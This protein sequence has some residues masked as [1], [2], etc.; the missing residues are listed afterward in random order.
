MKQT[1]LLLLILSGVLLCPAGAVSF[2]DVADNAWYAPAVEDVEARGLMEG[3]EDSRF[4]PEG[5]L[6]RAMVVTALWRMAGQPTAAAPVP[7]QDVPQDTWY[8][9]AVAWAAE[10]GAVKGF[11]PWVFGPDRPVTREQL[12]V[13]FYRWAE[14]QG[15]DISSDMGLSWKDSED[16]S[17][18]AW[19]AVAWAAERHLLQPKQPKFVPDYITTVDLVLEPGDSATRAEVAVFLSRF[20]RTFSDEVLGLTP[21]SIAVTTLGGT[22]PYLVVTSPDPS[23][24]GVRTVTL[25]ADLAHQRELMHRCTLGTSPLEI[26]AGRESIDTYDSQGRLTYLADYTYSETAVFSYLIGYDIQGNPAFVEIQTEGL[27]GS[28]RYALYYTQGET[29]WVLTGVGRDRTPLQRF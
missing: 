5:T 22:V 18:W 15:Y 2:S 8:A 23:G 21:A 10:N 26:I 12:A 16:T 3:V 7:F 11:S 6:T 1:I 9:A 19:A 24:E 4:Q 17:S 13:I 28:A 20:C 29:G 25:R 14:H 27:F